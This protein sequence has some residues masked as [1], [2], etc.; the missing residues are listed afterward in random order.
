MA[1]RKAPSYCVEIV[2]QGYHTQPFVTTLYTAPLDAATRSWWYTK[3]AH[4]NQAIDL[5]AADS[6]AMAHS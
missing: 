5:A 6:L 1:T 2:G 3:S 4:L